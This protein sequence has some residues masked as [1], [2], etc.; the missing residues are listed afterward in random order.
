MRNNAASRNVESLAAKKADSTAVVQVTKS[1]TQPVLGVPVDEMG[2]ELTRADRPIVGRMFTPRV[3]DRRSRVR[4]PWTADQIISALEAAENGDMG[5]QA[6]LSE[7]MQDRD[8]AYLGF[9]QTRILAP[10]KLPWS[11]E[12]ADESAEAKEIAEF[13][14]AEIRAIPNFQQAHRDMFSAAGPGV[15]ALWIDWRGCDCPPKPNGDPCNCFKG[16]RSHGGKA[17]KS[18]YRI[19]GIHFINPKRYRF[20]WMEEKFLILPDLDFGRAKDLGLMTVNAGPTRFADLSAAGLGIEPPPW[21]VLIHRSRV[22]SGHPA[23][24]GIDRVCALHFYLRINALNDAAVYCEI[25]GMPFRVAKYPPGMLDED[26]AE[27]AAAMDKLGSD[28]AAIVSNLVDI[29]WLESKS[30]TGGGTPFFELLHECERQMQLAWLGQDQ[31]NTHNDAGGRT[32]VAEGGA[33]IRQD[34]VEADCIDV[35]TTYT[36]QLCKPIV[37]FSKYGWEK[38]STLCPRF[39]IRYE[40]PEDLV[41]KAEVAAILYPKLKLPITYNMLAKEFGKSL[42]EGFKDGDVIIDYSAPAPVVGA[43]VDPTAPP[44]TTPPK[45]KPAQPAP[46]SGPRRIVAASGNFAAE[47]ADSE[48]VE[49]SYASTQVNITGAVA[50]QV[51]DVATGIPD[52]ALTG[53]GREDKPHVTVKY[54]IDPSVTIEELRKVVGPRAAGSLTL[55]PTAFFAAP[56]YDVVFLTVDSPD[57]VAL[58]KAIVDAVKTTATH[59]NYVPHLALAYVES[60]RG[61]E[62]A[63]NG[64]LVGVKF[65]YT[66]VHYYDTQRNGTKIQA[67]R[68]HV[69][70]TPPKPKL[71]TTFYE[72]RFYKDGD[73]VPEGWPDDYYSAATKASYMTLSQLIATE[74]DRDKRIAMERDREMMRRDCWAMATASEAAPATVTGQ[75]AIDDLQDR[76]MERAATIYQSLTAQAREVVAKATTLEEIPGLLIAAYS[77]LDTA[78][79]EVLTRR[80]LFVARLQGM[81]SAKR[82]PS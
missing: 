61:H 6:D 53:Q 46:K 27:L 72:P 65:D 13:V 9:R 4:P 21:K 17:P 49:H 29:D 78:D 28:A 31:T 37:G 47:T 8:A 20:H 33:P 12:P 16:G 80:T 26:K 62:F 39:K 57:L 34:L 45:E 15:S 42:P 76:A 3:T 68:G 36:M 64:A 41:Q 30:R 40:L 35:Q 82:T 51:F 79:L 73:M 50:A 60:G 19:D 1:D 23:K 22:K 32:Q 67:I 75:A 48:T 74:S 63:G 18:K 81:A 24:A 66:S 52:D 69:R 38:A 59:P 71:A 56:D 77:E 7:A 10:S 44:I 55:G 58:N 43:I 5:P 2:M 70:V 54:G 25:Y 11:I 14:K